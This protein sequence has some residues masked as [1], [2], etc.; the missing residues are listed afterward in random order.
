MAQ[1]AAFPGIL[2]DVVAAD[3]V[4]DTPCTTQ[5]QAQLH[6]EAWSAYIPNSSASNHTAGGL[7]ESYTDRYQPP[8]T[9]TPI[10]APQY[11]H[12]PEQ[13]NPFNSRG[14][15]L[16]YAHT[17]YNTRTSASTYSYQTSHVSA[18]TS[19]PPPVWGIPHSGAQQQ[20]SGCQSQIR[21]QY[22]FHSNAL[23]RA[24]PQRVLRNVYPHVNLPV[25][26]TVKATIPLADLQTLAYKKHADMKSTTGTEDQ[27]NI[28]PKVTRNEEG[29][30]I[31]APVPI[32]HHE[33]QALLTRAPNIV[34][35]QDCTYTT[36]GPIEDGESAAKDLTPRAPSPDTLIALTEP[37]LLDWCF[38]DE[39]IKKL[40]EMIL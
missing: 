16:H 22:P 1:D 12:I 27:E 10:L 35:L 11:A 21:T 3:Q 32:R 39:M 20:L 30:K 5:P 33:M 37:Y 28:D 23:S 36:V 2:A 8:S 7:L 26:K 29:R 4:N 25:S 13:A 38:D 24:R 34:Q 6:Q 31:E 9:Y 19:V 15:D 14:S 18:P 40:N 17:L